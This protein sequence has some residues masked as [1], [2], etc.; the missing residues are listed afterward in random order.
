MCHIV[1]VDPNRDYYT[2]HGLHQ[3]NHGK[4]KTAK[5]LSPKLLSVIQRTKDI[6]IRLRWTKDHANNMRDGTQNQVKNPPSTTTTEQ[7][8][9]ALRTSNRIKKP[10]KTMNEIFLGITGPPKKSTIGTSVIHTT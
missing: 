4:A 9:L 6:P 2:K 1:E 5:Q 3:N 10:P 7:N 8:N